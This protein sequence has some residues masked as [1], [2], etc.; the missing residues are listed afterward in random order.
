MWGTEKGKRAELWEWEGS[1]GLRAWSGT[2]CY[3]APSPCSHSIWEPSPHFSSEGEMSFMKGKFM[4]LVDKKCLLLLNCPG[5]LLEFAR[6][7]SDNFWIC[8][9]KNASQWTN[10]QTK[11]YRTGETTQWA[12]EIPA[13]AVDLGSTTGFTWWK[14]NQFTQVCPLTFTCA[15]TCPHTDAQRKRVLK[16]IRI[17]TICIPFLCESLWSDHLQALGKQHKRRLVFPSDCISFSTAFSSN[18]LYQGD[19]LG[20]GLF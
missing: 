1:L 4:S 11:P 14:G 12:K 7:S 15:V 5:H 6:L 9:V 10:K 20:L 19:V 3:G 2:I 16:A 8:R 17:D 13:N 18:N